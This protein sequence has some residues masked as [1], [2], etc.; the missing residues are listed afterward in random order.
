MYKS[1]VIIFRTKEL[2]RKFQKAVNKA[3]ELQKEARKEKKLQKFRKIQNM[4]RKLYGNRKLNVFKFS[5][6][7]ENFE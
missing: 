7:K 4:R 6:L 2:Y 1:K 5:N 3:I